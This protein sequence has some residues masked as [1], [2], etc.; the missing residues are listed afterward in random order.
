MCCGR[1]KIY[2]MEVVPTCQPTYQ[3]VPVPVQVVPV[4]TVPVYYT[5]VQQAPPPPR[6]VQTYYYSAQPV[7]RYITYY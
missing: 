5:V 1:K 3:V 7:T 6:P 4:Q 2:T